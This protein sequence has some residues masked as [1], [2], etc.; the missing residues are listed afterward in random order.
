MYQIYSEKVIPS[1]G[2]LFA[3]DRESYQYLVDSIKNHPN[4]EEFAKMMR[5]A[6]FKKVSWHNL[7]FGAVAIHIGTKI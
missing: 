2:E 7:T 1:L 6:G 3:K 4:Q 5:D